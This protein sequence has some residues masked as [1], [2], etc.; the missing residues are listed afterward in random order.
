MLKIDWS[1]P[2]CSGRHS[3]EHR[4]GGVPEVAPTHL[5]G[6]SYFGFKPR[7]HDELM[8]TNLIDVR[9]VLSEN[10]KEGRERLQK[11]LD[12][13]AGAPLQAASVVG[14]EVSLVAA[15]DQ[16]VVK[17]TAAGDGDS[18]KRHMIIGRH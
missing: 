9:L 8:V 6:R 11:V 10:E 7:A 2:S 1:K 15:K 12:V 4:Y 17:G 13:P 3:Y 5:G 16:E 14:E 18:K